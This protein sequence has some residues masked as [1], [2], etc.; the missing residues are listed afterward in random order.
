VA[1]NSNTAVYLECVVG[2]PDLYRFVSIAPARG[3]RIHSACMA[4][5]TMGFPAGKKAVWTRKH[6]VCWLLLDKKNGRWSGNT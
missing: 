3:K 6:L 4:T 5:V 2:Q 1:L